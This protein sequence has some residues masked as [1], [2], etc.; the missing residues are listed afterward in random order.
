VL[1][2]VRMPRLNAIIE[3]WVTT[4]R[5]EPSDRALVW[6]EAHLRPAL[7]A[8]EQRYTHHRLHRVLASAAPL[9]ALPQAREPTEL[10]HR[11]VRRRVR[12]GGVIHEHRHVA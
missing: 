1:T 7:R 11:V 6:N 2:G 3:R 5:T 9:P 8:Y 10:D 12:L 4:L